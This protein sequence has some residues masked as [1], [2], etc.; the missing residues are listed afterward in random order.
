MKIYCLK[1]CPSE[2]TMYD[3]RYSNLSI[4]ELRQYGNKYA[5]Y[6]VCDAGSNYAYGWWESLHLSRYQG[7]LTRLSEFYYKFE[8]ELLEQYNEE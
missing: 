3:D 6:W 2:D 5:W 8:P 1:K 4:Y 7:D